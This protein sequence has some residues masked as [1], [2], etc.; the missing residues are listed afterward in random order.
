MVGSSVILALSWRLCGY[1]CVYINHLEGIDVCGHINRICR[2]KNTSVDKN[3][4]G[5]KI[6]VGIKTFV[7]IKIFVVINISSRAARLGKRNI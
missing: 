5:V 7:R 4:C 3:I 1:V 6:F 2:D